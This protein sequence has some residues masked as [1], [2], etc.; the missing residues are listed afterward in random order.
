M[1][2]NTIIDMLKKSQGNMDAVGRVIYSNCKML[3]SCGFC[4][5]DSYLGA[6]KKVHK[7]RLEKK[8]ETILIEFV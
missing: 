6:L 7:W 1:E 2:E 4:Y 3:L 5:H 8:E